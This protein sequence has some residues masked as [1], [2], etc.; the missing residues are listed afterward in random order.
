MF[1]RLAQNLADSM[2]VDGPALYSSFCTRLSG[3][4][5]DTGATGYRSRSLLIVYLSRQRVLHVGQ[6]VGQHGHGGR[7][8]AEFT[9]NDLVERVGG[10]MVVIEVGSTVLHN[11]KGRHS[12]IRHGGDVRAGRISA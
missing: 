8:F 7:I 5:A 3:N 10:G 6:G 1:G 11:A 12:K 4:D 2:G 9:G